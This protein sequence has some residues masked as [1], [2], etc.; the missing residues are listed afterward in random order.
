MVS[1]HSWG[2]S[3]QEAAGQRSNHPQNLPHDPC[4]FAKAALLTGL[5][6]V[7]GQKGLGPGKQL[8]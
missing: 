6:T 7:L 4:S 1:G 5:V 2:S 3:A 8:L